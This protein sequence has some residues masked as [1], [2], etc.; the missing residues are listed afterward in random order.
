MWRMQSFDWQARRS[1]IRSK[2]SRRRDRCLRVE[3]LE[4]RSMLSVVT[5]TNNLDVN[6]GDTSSIAN[7]IANDGGD[8]IALREAI[9]AANLTGGADTVNFDTSGLF[10][11]P[12]TFTL[13]GEQL[14]ILESLTINGPGQQ[15]LTIDAEQ[16]S[17]I[18]NI[19]ATTGDFA[20]ARMT[21]TGGK[22]IAGGLA[23]AGGAIRSITTGNLTIDQSTVTGNSTTASNANGGGIFS[24]GNVTLSH[25]TV[26]GNS[27]A[28]SNAFGG[29][30]ASS[31]DVTF[32]SSTV[33]GNSSTCGSG[34]GVFSLRD[35][36]L[37]NSTVSDN[38]TACVGAFGGGISSSRDVTLTNSTVSG[39]STAGSGS[40]G[41]G[42]ASSRNVT[43]T[44]STVSGNSTAGS[45]ALG[46]GIAS[47]GD[48]TLTNSTVSG[49][50]SASSNADG[51]GIHSFGDVTLSHSTVANNRATD[52]NATG[53]GIWNDN[54]PIV[55]TNS[56]VAGN[57]AAGGM[58]DIDPGTGT[59]SVNFSLVG[60][61]VTPDPGRS[62]DNLVTNNPLLG[63]LADNG[64]P[65]Q[66][67]A[68]L[69]GSLAIDTGSTGL[70][71]VAL[72]G[73]AMHSSDFN[74]VSFAAD[75]AID[76][77]PNTFTATKIDDTNPTWELLLPID[78]A[79]AEIVLRN[80]VG[81]CPSRL[82]D[83][84]VQILDAAGVV[85]FTSELLNPENNLGGGMLDQG[86]TTLTAD[87][88]SETG[89]PVQG[90]TVRVTRTSDP[91]FSG[92]GGTNGVSG[93]E[94]ILSLSE[95]EIFT[96]T[97]DFDQRGA[98]FVRMF[99]DP[100]AAGSGTDIGAVEVQPIGASADFDSDGDIDGA[101]FLAWQLGFGKAG[102]LTSDGDADHDGDVDAVDLA[103]WGTTFGQSSG[104]MAT[105]L[106]A[107]APAGEVE[108]LANLADRAAADLIDAAMATDLLK[109]ATDEEELPVFQNPIL[110]D[111]ASA[112]TASSANPYVW[113]RGYHEDF[114]ALSSY[115]ASSAAEESTSPWLSDELLEQVFD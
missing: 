86:P 40:R 88:V 22:M 67:H 94:N 19:T 60:T 68:P 39:N 77:N 14:M 7:L 13:G 87:V 112:S 85:Q 18:F 69:P 89:G 32:I 76:G 31:G 58:N 65:T 97:S 80:R 34:G 6:N 8:G 42:I 90:R 92:T 107:S 96:R 111:A 110:V 59:F 15:L 5:V 11:T 74:V 106:Q 41:G 50:S 46:G 71:N 29:G 20:I 37:I 72:G 64:G 108:N 4:H 115:A 28:G 12:Q 83:I 45:N 91:D 114:D 51:G 36:T 75:R 73:D 101:D 82:R 16:A 63:L 57:T 1:G 48:V 25:S 26:S 54:N 98:P 103:E 30:I 84:T 24:S 35:V 53:G 47:Y 104:A 44:H 43:L 23:G 17:R 56:I 100:D 105:R 49:N 81:C 9:T 3:P 33:S 109:S 113:T 78:F 102:A 55:F 27:T 99:N 62:E 52:R 10:S 2:S 70:V 66:T 93:E 79:I 95:V 61:A 21:L 38:S